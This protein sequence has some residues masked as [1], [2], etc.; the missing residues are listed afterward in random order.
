MK[1]VKFR[2]LF[3]AA[4][5]IF[6]LWGA[7]VAAKGVFDLFAGEPEANHFSPRPWEFVTRVQWANWAGFEVAYGLACAGAAFLLWKYAPR[8]PEYLE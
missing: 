6:V 4:G 1:K 7:A 8:V 5:W 2:G 3:V